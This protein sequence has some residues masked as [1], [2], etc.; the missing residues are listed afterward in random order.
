MKGEVGEKSE[1]RRTRRESG[2]KENPIHILCMYST[3]YIYKHD[4]KYFLLFFPVPFLSKSFTLCFV[5]SYISFIFSSKLKFQFYNIQVLTNAFIRSNIYH[6]KFEQIC[7]ACIYTYRIN[8]LHPFSLFFS[9]FP[10]KC[11]YKIQH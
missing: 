2:R 5:I 3:L 8:Q 4:T 6:K 9:L 7:S 11:L 10:N 1:E